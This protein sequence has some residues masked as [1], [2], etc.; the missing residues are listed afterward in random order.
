MILQLLTAFL[1]NDNALRYNAEMAFSGIK[2]S[3]PREVIRGLV[4]IILDEQVELRPLAAVLLR[5]ITI[6]EPDLW[7][8][9]SQEEIVSIRV[10][11]LQ[12][13]E[14]AAAIGNQRK[15]IDCGKL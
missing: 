15:L 14:A 6:R 2:K 12:G 13:L 7:N 11:L 10:H 8:A 1:S 5:G 4:A 9:L 3:N